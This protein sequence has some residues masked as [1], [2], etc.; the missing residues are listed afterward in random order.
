MVLDIDIQNERLSLG[1]KQLEPDPWDTIVQRYPVGSK[2]KGRITSIADFG[3]FVEV[4]EGIE[5]LIHNSQLGLSRNQ[6]VSDVFKLG[7][8]VEPEVTNVDREERRISLSLK[9]VKQR[10]EKETLAEFTED[11]SAPVTFG[12]LLREKIDSSG[13]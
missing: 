11:R 2:V 6:N 10:E 8:I 5:G 7:D 12:D 13:K 3:L 9:S 1:I 4:E